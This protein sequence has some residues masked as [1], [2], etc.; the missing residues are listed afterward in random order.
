MDWNMISAISTAFMA[1]VVLIAAILAVLQLRE[2]SRSRAVSA[3]MELSRFLQREEIRKARGI[4]INIPKDRNLEDWS[5]EEREAAEKAS[6]TYDVAGIMV[7]K[8]LIEEDL[9]V[10]EWRDSIIKCWEAAEPMI[11]EYRKGRGEDFWDA[12]EMLYERAKKIEIAH[13]MA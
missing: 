3:F 11:M 8:K 9:I 4:L 1:F 12:F 7:F 10:N 6:H 13:N 2:I 5:V